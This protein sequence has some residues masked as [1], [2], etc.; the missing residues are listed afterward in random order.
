MASIGSLLALLAPSVPAAAAEQPSPVTRTE[1][2]EP[3]AFGYV[4]GDVLTRRIELDAER[5]V[6]L[7]TDR[8]PKPGRVS[9]W[10][11][12]ARV[13]HESSRAGA[14]TRYTIILTYQLMNAAQELRALVLPALRIPFRTAAGAV[15]EDVPEYAFTAGPLTPQ[16][17]LA[18]EGL[19][20]M[21]P[22]IPPQPL[23][24]T[25]VRA[26]LAL[27][28]AGLCAIVL[29]FA[30]AYFGLPFF[31]RSRGPFAR[32]LRR[33]NAAARVGDPQQ[34]MQA[35]MKAM[36]GAFD[37]TAGATVFG[38]Q[39]EGFFAVHE[40][41]APLRPSVERFFAGSREAF[42]GTGCAQLSVPWLAALCRDLRDRERGVA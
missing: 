4:I 24:T 7:D 14:H 42:F 26:R 21:Q 10:L 31:S 34:A 41:F 9:S 1:I 25:A 36:H 12:L 37:E 13:T 35:A 38:E 15:F 29:Y 19:E 11:E 5:G 17:V 2:S 40:R 18:R 6:S 8:L 39:L 3:R 30:Y 23:S 16:Y 33:V 32:A 22:D 28:G 27:Y 20:E